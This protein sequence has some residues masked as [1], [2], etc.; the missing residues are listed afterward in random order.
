M[1]SDWFSKPA[2]AWVAVAPIAGIVSSAYA[3]DMSFDG[4]SDIRA[5]L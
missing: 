4:V 1:S 5:A 2:S 3:S